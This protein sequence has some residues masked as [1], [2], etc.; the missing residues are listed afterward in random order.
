V[1]SSMQAGQIPFMR[2]SADGVSFDLCVKMFGGRVY[3]FEFS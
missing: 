3:Y 1:L 2:F